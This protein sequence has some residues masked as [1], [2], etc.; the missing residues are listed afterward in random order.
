MK[1]E[2]DQTLNYRTNKVATGTACDPRVT[3]SRIA[4]PSLLTFRTA[5]GLPLT[6]HRYR[7]ADR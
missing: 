4:A 2:F 3:R 6:G 5:P 7:N 1:N